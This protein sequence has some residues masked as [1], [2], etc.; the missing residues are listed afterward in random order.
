MDLR[1]FWGPSLGWKEGNLVQSQSLEVDRAVWAPVSPDRQRGDRLLVGD[2]NC[3][4]N[5]IHSVYNIT[6]VSL[7]ISLYLYFGIITVL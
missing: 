2:E 3:E 7:Y 1:A 4:I 6:I 5:M